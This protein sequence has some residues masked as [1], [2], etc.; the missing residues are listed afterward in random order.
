M[1]ESITPTVYLIWILAW[2]CSIHWDLRW[3]S[4]LLFCA[5]SLWIL[6]ACSGDC[7]RKCEETQRHSWTQ[8]S[9]PWALPC[10]TRAAP[11]LSSVSGKSRSLEPRLKWTFKCCYGWYGWSLL[12]F[13][14][15]TWQ[16]LSLFIQ[17]INVIE[18]GFDKVSLIYSLFT[19]FSALT[20][21][22]FWEWIKILITH[23]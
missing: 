19:T 16:F 10:S 12:Q 4:P 22:F 9:T 18:S 15:C 2:N 3:N 23:S 14:L 5:C 11:S 13:S 7:R 1:Y 8:P 21:W 6:L 17:H 20:S